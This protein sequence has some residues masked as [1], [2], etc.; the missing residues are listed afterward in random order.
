MIGLSAIDNIVKLKT[1]DFSKIVTIFDMKSNIEKSSIL[2][3]SDTLKSQKDAIG[4]FKDYD[5]DLSDFLESIFNDA[6]KELYMDK[7]VLDSIKSLY[8]DKVIRVIN[9][10]LNIL[11][12]KHL[13]NARIALLRNK[14]G[15]EQSLIN[16]SHRIVYD[17]SGR[18]ISLVD[19]FRKDLR[20]VLIDYVNDLVIIS[21]YKEGKQVAYTVNENGEKNKEFLISNYMKYAEI[22]N[23]IFHPNVQSL[24]YIEE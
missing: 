4:L 1:V 17:A 23:S 9:S 18:R 3:M 16:Y 21:A 12:S 6:I 14:A 19:K 24:A 20:K 13:K 8:S 5:F 11:L 7:V 22:K 2:K 10:N 15:K